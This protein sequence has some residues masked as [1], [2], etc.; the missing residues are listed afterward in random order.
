LVTSYQKMSTKI[1]PHLR[2]VFG[3]KR[4]NLC[5]IL[6]IIILNKKDNETNATIHGYFRP[7]DA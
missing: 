4:A 2:I 5:R 1:Y 6:F 7:T 3:T